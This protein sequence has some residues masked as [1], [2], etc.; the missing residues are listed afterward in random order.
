MAASNITPMGIIPEDHMNLSIFCF[1]DF[2]EP[3]GQISDIYM[4]VNYTWAMLR[5]VVRKDDGITVN[6]DAS[7]FT[8]LS[9]SFD[10]YDLGY[11][12]LLDDWVLWSHSS[13]PAQLSQG[14]LGYYADLGSYNA[15]LE[16]G[17]HQ[18]RGTCSFTLL[19]TS[20]MY[21][22]YTNATS[23]NV[24]YMHNKD[25]IPWLSIGFVIKEIFNVGLDF[26]G[27]NDEVA[28]SVNIY[29]GR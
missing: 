7:L 6:W 19:P 26:S 24:N 12:S 16:M 18:L 17:A 2:Y 15:M 1:Y 25:P 22:E 10:S 23:I 27:L 14:G 8:F 3:T 21:I 13:S 28:D 5:P 4:L 20:P 29:Y 11:Y 9:G